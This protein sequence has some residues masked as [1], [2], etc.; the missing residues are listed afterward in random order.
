M[1][2]QKTTANNWKEEHQSPHTMVET[3]QERRNLTEY[4]QRAL[5]ELKKMRLRAKDQAEIIA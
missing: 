1:N 2:N 5:K 3:L 4:E